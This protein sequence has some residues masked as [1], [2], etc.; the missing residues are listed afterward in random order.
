MKGFNISTADNW[1]G[2]Y[3]GT[4][5]KCGCDLYLKES[6]KR[7]ANSGCN[8]SELKEQL[9]KGRSTSMEASAE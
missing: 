7:C 3:M 8:Y 2:L 1:D 6:F 9:S 4:C 5:P